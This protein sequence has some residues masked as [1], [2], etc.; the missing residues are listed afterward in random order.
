ML[1]RVERGTEPSGLRGGVFKTSLPLNSL[2]LRTPTLTQA[3][4]PC[5]SP[6]FDSPLGN[7]HAP[8]VDERAPFVDVP[9]ST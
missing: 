6:R 7:E 3:G 1:E 4:S 2:A 9:K 8:F 5:P